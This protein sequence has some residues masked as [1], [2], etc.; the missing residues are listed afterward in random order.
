MAFGKSS[1]T[2]IFLSGMK[3]WKHVHQRVEEHEKILMHRN[4]AGAYFLWE[5]KSDIENLLAHG[6][7]SAN[8][9]LVR[10]CSQVF[11]RVIELTKVIGK[12]G[13]CYRGTPSEAAYTLDNSCM[14]HGNFL[15]MI[16]LLSKYDLCLK[17]HLSECIENSKKKRVRG[18]L[19]TFLSKTTVNSV[20]KTIQYSIKECIAREVKEA[21]MFSLQIDTTYFTR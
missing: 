15:E 18:S 10:K 16:I 3:D 20:L 19:V 14:D 9:E 11:E 21:G 2:N 1:E 5:S 17:E 8:R 6:E 12:K 13:I 7:M 4:C